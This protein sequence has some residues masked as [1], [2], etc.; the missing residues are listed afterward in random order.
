[1]NL[2][3]FVQRKRLR[4]MLPLDNEHSGM[5]AITAVINGDES[6]VYGVPSWWPDCYLVGDST[7][8]L[9]LAILLKHRNA[10]SAT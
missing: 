1:M 10:K 4:L 3:G 7:A 8:A 9:Y 2:R 5:A 6:S